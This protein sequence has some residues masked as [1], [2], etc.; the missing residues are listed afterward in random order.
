MAATNNLQT[1]IF[2]PLLSI[3]VIKYFSRQVSS[4]RPAQ[5]AEQLSKTLEETEATQRGHWS[6]VLM[7]CQ[8]GTA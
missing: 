5:K 1:H 6:V 3:L 2:F 8:I 7:L 4:T